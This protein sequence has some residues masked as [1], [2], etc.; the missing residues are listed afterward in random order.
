MNNVV[1]GVDLYFHVD[2]NIVPA[3]GT[4]ETCKYGSI[5]LH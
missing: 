3:T 1:L 5:S 2:L 4:L